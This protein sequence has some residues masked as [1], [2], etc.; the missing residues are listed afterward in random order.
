[1]FTSLQPPPDTLQLVAALRNLHLV[2]SLT[3]WIATSGY[4]PAVLLEVVPSHSALTL[5]QNT[6][7]VNTE[8]ATSSSQA[9]QRVEKV[10]QKL[11][12]HVADDA[13]SAALSSCRDQDRQD[14]T[15]DDTAGRSVLEEA[16]ST[17]ERGRLLV[18]ATSQQGTESGGQ[19]SATFTEHVD[20]DGVEDGEWSSS[21]PI[22]LNARRQLGQRQAGVGLSLA[23]Y[24]APVGVGVPLVALRR[25]M[26]TWLD[27][28]PTP[29]VREDVQ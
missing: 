29:Q 5:R 6:T 19:E 8:H 24:T 9:T 25:A 12:S 15:S 28:K 11:T 20:L 1:M 14:C 2:N 26:L 21:L 13:V 4:R 22:P 10:Q 16:N 17:G 27:L 23:I 18:Q 3:A 7:L